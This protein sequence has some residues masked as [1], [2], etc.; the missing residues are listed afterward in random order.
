MERYA[1]HLSAATRVVDL[2]PASTPSPV[3]PRGAGDGFR[4]SL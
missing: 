1:L 4:K 2:L 3:N